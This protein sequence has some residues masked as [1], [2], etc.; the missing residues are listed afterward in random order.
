LNKS[1]PGQRDSQEAV[2]GGHDYYTYSE[3]RAEQIGRDGVRQLLRLPVDLGR[4]EVGRIGRL[5]NFENLK[6]KK[7]EIA[8]RGRLQETSFG[9][10]LALS[11]ACAT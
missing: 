2:G 4:V 3:E 5:E 10:G 1:L 9:V 6:K 11:K 7:K 8:L